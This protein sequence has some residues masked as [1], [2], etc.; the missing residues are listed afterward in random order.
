MSINPFIEHMA[1]ALAEFHLA[2]HGGAEVV[3]LMPD[4]PNWHLFINEAKA[5]FRA[6]QELPESKGMN[7]RA[8]HYSRSHIDA[9]VQDALR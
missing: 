8:R 3:Q 9:M 6:L 1:K 7:C 4:R 2:S 5:A